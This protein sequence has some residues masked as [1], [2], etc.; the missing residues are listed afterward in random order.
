MI[1]ITGIFATNKFLYSITLHQSSIS[2]ILTQ[3]AA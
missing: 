2:Q 1:I 3:S